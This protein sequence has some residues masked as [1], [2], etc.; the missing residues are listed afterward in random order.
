MADVMEWYDA[1][2]RAALRQMGAALGLDDPPRFARLVLAHE[3]AKR[4]AEEALA[5]SV[6]RMQRRTVR[7]ARRQYGGRWRAFVKGAATRG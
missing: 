4:R 6:L 1:R 7:M 5:W 2:A 3:T